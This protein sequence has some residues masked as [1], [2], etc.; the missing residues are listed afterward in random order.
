VVGGK[1][2][3][4]VKGEGLRD[5]GR[6]DSAS[7]WLTRPHLFRSIGALAMDTQFC[8]ADLCSLSDA[9]IYIDKTTASRSLPDVGTRK[10]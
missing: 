5:N 9:I 2:T 10:R 1:Y 8:S 7:E 3:A 4:I 6:T